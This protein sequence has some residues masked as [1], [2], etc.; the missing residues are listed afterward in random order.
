MDLRQYIRD[1]PDF[2]V[3]GI[4]FRDITPLMQEPEAFGEGRLFAMDLRQYIRDIPDFPVEGILF[5]DITPL[6]QEPEAF[7]YVID[8]M[9]EHYEGQGVDVIL[10]IE[11]RGFLIGAPLAY[12]LGKPFVPVRK[13]GRLPY[14]TRSVKYA[15]EYGQNVVEV[16]TDA[17]SEGQRAVILDDLLATGGTMAA[18]AELVESMG[19][20]VAGLAAVIE[21]IDLDGRERLSGYGVFSLVQ[22]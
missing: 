13:E 10:G 4:L 20:E 8:R 7:G 2:P 14:E 17:I 15:L 16:H 1:I 19:G 6:M 3:E 18:G 21:L 11:A 9:A 12:K 22:Y 5:R